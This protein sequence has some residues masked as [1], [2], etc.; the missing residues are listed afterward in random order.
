MCSRWAPRSPRFAR[1]AR[2]PDLLFGFLSSVSVCLRGDA[3]LSS[4]FARLARH[5]DMLL[6]ALSSV[7][8]CKGGHLALF[9]LR[10]ARSAA[11]HV[12]RLFVFCLCLCLLKGR[13]SRLASL[14]LLG[15]RF[16]CGVHIRACGCIHVRTHVCV[17]K[18]G[19]SLASL[20]SARSAPIF[21]VEFNVRVRIR[22]YASIH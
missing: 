17:R 10:S 13:L 8:V 11:G 5:P 19:T 7:S 21:I 2:R 12:V 20:R 9:S 15:A 14:G 4:H 3:S 1:L 18:G 6:G 22:V 16:H